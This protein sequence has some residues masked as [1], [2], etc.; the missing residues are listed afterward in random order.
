[1]SVLKFNWKNT[2]INGALAHI[3][4]SD[5]KD[6]AILYDFMWFTNFIQW[7]MFSSYNSVSHNFCLKI[8]RKSRKMEEILIK[9]IMNKVLNSHNYFYLCYQWLLKFHLK[10]RNRCTSYFMQVLNQ[11]VFY[12]MSQSAVNHLSLSIM[13]QFVL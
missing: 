10:S 7:L 9:C 1:M 8:Q 11:V 2:Q 4:A 3:L 6:E 5:L 13:F 12:L